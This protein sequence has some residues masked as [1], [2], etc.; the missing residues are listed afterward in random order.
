[1]DMVRKVFRAPLMVVVMLPLLQGCSIRSMAIN[2]MAN[3]LSGSGATFASDNDPELVRQAVPFALKTYEALL[4]QRPHHRGL[5]LAATKGFTEYAY[6]FV[7]TDALLLEDTDPATA[8]VDRVRARRLY[9][10]ARDYG[11]RAL[12]L[13]RPGIAEALRQDPEAAVAGFDQNDVELLYWTAASWGAAI[14]AGMDDPELL[15]DYPAVRAL[16]TRALAL[17]PDWDEGALHEAMISLESVPEAMGGSEER[18][19]QQFRRAVALSGGHKAG[20]YVTLASGVVVR[21]QDRAEFESLL[22][23]ALAVDPDT[24]PRYRLA[25]LIAQERA[26]HLLAREDELFFEEPDS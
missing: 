15:A 9:L 17:D 26:R 3:G 14:A 25:N 19:R 2:A 21:S 12:A 1:M 13:D 22:K 6:A 16:L 10:R 11:L 23:A 7:D 24:E 18:A 4:S 8:R 5:L 20:P